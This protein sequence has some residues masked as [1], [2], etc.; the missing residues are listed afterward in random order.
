[1]I[2]V[3]ELERRVVLLGDRA[4][5]AQLGQSGWNEQVARLL[6]RIR[7]GQAGAGIVE[8]LQ[9]LTP[10]L[11]AALPRAADDEN[12]LPDSVLRA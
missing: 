12:E 11:A 6:E 1:L 4:L 5:D 7:Q 2:F 8:M 3:S 10:P 9:Q